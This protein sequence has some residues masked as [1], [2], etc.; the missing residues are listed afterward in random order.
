VSTERTL[1]NQPDSNEIWA[2]IGGHFDSLGQIIAEFVDN[3]IANIMA[4]DPV[5]R[6]V[7]VRL[8]DLQTAVLVQIEDT[9]TGIDN[10][11]NAFTLGGKEGRLGP[12]NEHGFGMKHAL[13]SANHGNDKWSVYTRTD[14]HVELAVYD[15]IAAPYVYDGQRVTTIEVVEAAWPG[16]YNGT[17]TMVE[18]E[19][20][21]EMFD[22]LGAGIPGRAGFEALVGYLVEFLGYVYSGL[23][24]TNAASIKVTWEP[25]GSP[26]RTSPVGAVTPDW[27]QYYR[28]PGCGTDT[29]DLGNGSVGLKFQY[30]AIQD[31]SYKRYYRTNTRCSG[32]EIRQNGRLID[33]N[34]F[35]E[36]WGREP[37][38]MY[39]HL[40]VIVDIEA[41]DRTKLP[42]T[43]TSKNGYRQGD[44]RLTAVYEWVRRHMPDPPKEIGQ[45]VGEADLFDELKN[46]KQLH[47]P[48]P[49]TVKR[50]QGLFTSVG[51]TRV[52]ADLY[53]SYGTELHLYEGKKDITTVKDVYQL[54]MYW[55]GALQDGL[56]PTLGILIA[57]QHPQSVV[58]VLAVVN[59]MNDAEGS[60]YR[61]E[62]RT[63]KDEG[64]Q[65]PN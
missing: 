5:T 51:E 52:R 26:P 18:F 22:T 63:W 9:G 62:T 28:P 43:R 56:H 13:A 33:N 31:S 10:L 29:Y 48:E 34:I 59:T 19:C 3:S 54:K 2:G 15:K 32:L 30:G 8:L 58:D 61:F 20:T 41:D 35:F 14:T 38:N 16:R 64:I 21:L 39:N 36:V 27:L 53:L 55:D 37:H 12:L 23:I 40:L 47:V 57:A 49:K 4:T 7:S 44:P 65:Y 42:P 1:N 46:H 50:E 24:Q 6:D 17:G 60:P 25:F 45:A 11:D